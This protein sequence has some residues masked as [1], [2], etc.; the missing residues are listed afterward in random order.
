MDF[1]QTHE[2]IVV[3]R[4]DHGSSA[5]ANGVGGAAPDVCVVVRVPMPPCACGVPVLSGIMVQ[6]VLRWCVLRMQVGGGPAVAYELDMYTPVYCVVL[7]CSR[8]CGAGTEWPTRHGELRPSQMC[9]PSAPAAVAWHTV[10]MYPL[11]CAGIHVRQAA[12]LRMALLT[13]ERLVWHCG[14]HT[15]KPD[16]A[17]WRR[18]PMTADLLCSAA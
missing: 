3:K 8:R 18:S 4:V 2:E 16:S 10:G 13:T 12:V 9:S 5:S 17:S 7:C 14:G 15:A 6:A 1:E 11:A